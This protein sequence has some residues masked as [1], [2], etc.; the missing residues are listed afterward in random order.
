MKKILFLC[1]AC[2]SLYAVVMPLHRGSVTAGYRD[3]ISACSPQQAGSIMERKDGKFITPLPGWGHYSYTISTTSDSAQYYFNQGLTL[4]YSYHPK[5]A[6]A[7]FKEANRFDTSSVM[8]SWG[9]LLARGPTYNGA[10][11]Y[12]MPP[13]VTNTM[14]KLQDQIAGSA[15][16]KEKEMAEAVISRYPAAVQTAPRDTLNRIYAAKMKILMN[17]YPGDIDIAALYVD[18]VMLIHPW[19]FWN[20]DGTPKEWTE[21]LVSISANIIKAKPQHPGALHY[22]IH[23]TEASRHPEVALANAKALRENFSGIAHMVH[24]ASHEYERN[25][26][27][28]EGIP[29]NDKADENLLL[30]DSLAPHLSLSRHSQHYFAVQAYCALSGAMSAESERTASRCSKSVSPSP[31]STYEQYLSMFPLLAQVRLGQ[32]KSVLEQ[33]P[34]D[35]KLSYASVL[36]HFG[37]GMALL[38]TGKTNEAEQQLRLLKER[39]TDPILKIRRIPFNTPLDGARI[40]EGILEGAIAFKQKKTLA[41]LAGFSQATSIEDRLIY[42]EPSDWMLPARQ[43]LGAYL[44]QAGQAATAEKIYREDLVWNPGNGWSSLGLYLSLKKQNKKTEMQFYRDAYLR[45]FEKAENIP[46][47]SAFIP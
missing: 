11:F 45:S 29:S 24:M 30:Y 17:K 14:L 33:R 2:C 16:T 26:L 28:A 25:G 12:T 34:P 9:Q 3:A 42:T 43:Y 47:A 36:F 19:D 13:D 1:I 44:L 8:A 41:A 21:E 10:H 4:Y 5:E 38:N 31:E 6:L 32:W 39:L 23:V 15:A 46:S 35:N 40:A 20:N 27:F 7:S 18:A 22:Q 37:W